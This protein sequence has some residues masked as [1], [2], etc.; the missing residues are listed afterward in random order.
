MFTPDPTKFRKP[1]LA[2]TI[3]WKPDPTLFWKLGPDPQLS[4]TYS[5]NSCDENTILQVEAKHF[6]SREFRFSLQHTIDGKINLDCGYEKGL[7]T[8][9]TWE[10]YGTD[11]SAQEYGL[12]SAFLIFPIPV[13]ATVDFMV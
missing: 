5:K 3:F 1:D 11:S 7:F 9:F 6:S 2:L 13:A 10:V 4:L 8:D 12:L